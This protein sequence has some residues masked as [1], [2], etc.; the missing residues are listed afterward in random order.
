MAGV[1]SS[2]SRACGQTRR[3]PALEAPVA[4]ISGVSGVA[5]LLTFMLAKPA[6]RPGRW[7]TTFVH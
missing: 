4:G 3:Y 6:T 7:D 5:L 1:R 2:C